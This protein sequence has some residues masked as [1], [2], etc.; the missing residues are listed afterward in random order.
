MNVMVCYKDLQSGDE[1]ARQRTRAFIN[2]TLKARTCDTRPMLD[3]ATDNSPAD[4]ATP[5]SPGAG[6]NSPG[7]RIAHDSQ[8]PVTDAK[9]PADSS[10]FDSHPASANTVG[11]TSGTHAW[12]S[13]TGSTISPSLGTATSYSGFVNNGVVPE[14]KAASNKAARCGSEGTSNSITQ[15]QLQSS[16]EHTAASSAVAATATAEKHIHVAMI[17]LSALQ[18][19]P[20][21]PHTLKDSIA[22]SISAVLQLLHDLLVHHLPNQDLDMTTAFLMGVPILQKYIAK[23]L[24]AR[25]QLQD[26]LHLWLARLARD[27]TL[28]HDDSLDSEDGRLEM[29]LARLMVPIAKQGDNALTLS[30]L[31]LDVAYFLLDNVRVAALVAAKHM[32]GVLDCFKHYASPNGNKAARFTIAAILARLH[33]EEVQAAIA[34]DPRL[35]GKQQPSCGWPEQQKFASE[36]LTS[37]LDLV[38]DRVQDQSRPHKNLQMA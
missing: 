37:H 7:T 19:I 2:R 29:A 25:T 3:R 22:A 18:W 17:A 34:Q 32:A 4:G 5:S 38:Y 31:R 10:T 8:Y 24:L 36:W 9:T 33:G 6:P 23:P 15:D 21:Q 11:A 14:I 13:S 27:E 28:Q 26:L 30:L 12:N 35:C 1:Q 20:R 16:P